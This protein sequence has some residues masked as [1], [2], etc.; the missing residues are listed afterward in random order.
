[1]KKIALFLPLLLVLA[2]CA[3]YEHFRYIT[4]EYEMPSKIFIATYDQTWGAVLEGMKKYDI[5]TKN[6]EAGVLKTRWMDNTSEV[7]FA[8]SSGDTNVKAAKFKLVVNVTKGFRNNREVTKVTIYKRQLVE[9]DMLQGWKEL[10]SDGIEEKVIL[11]RL[12]V[13]LKMDLKFRRLEEIKA[14]EEIQ[15]F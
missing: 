2:S 1:M 7:N 12:E 14:K 10:R 8:N 5:D 3:S 6:Q 15:N 4:E 13:I 9:Q 11:H